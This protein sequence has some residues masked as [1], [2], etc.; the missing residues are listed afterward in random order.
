MTRLVAPAQS[1][2]PSQVLRRQ[3]LS[4]FGQG[5][6]AEMECRLPLSAFP[7]NDAHQLVRTFKDEGW[8]VQVRREEAQVVF[9]FSNPPLGALSLSDAQTK[10]LQGLLHRM[11]RL[12]A[13]GLPGG[14]RSYPIV[15]PMPFRVL[16]T[17]L[18]LLRGDGLQVTLTLGQRATPKAVL[19]AL[20]VQGLNAESFPSRENVE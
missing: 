11:R 14:S 18:H 16:A 3:I 2:D 12:V 5:P 8:N 19:L 20:P 1:P 4:N 6:S 9:T 7:K 15:E 17:A 10:Q 13:G